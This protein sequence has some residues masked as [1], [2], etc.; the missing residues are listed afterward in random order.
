M[1]R[2]KSNR[3]WILILAIVLSVA[4]VVLVPAVGLADRGSDGVIGNNPS[5]GSGPP[6]PQGTGDPD[7]PSGSGKA[8]LQLGGGT[9]YGT[10]GSSG[11]GDAAE[12]GLAP[13]WK[14][15]IRIALGVLKTFYLRF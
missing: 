7:S 11:V 9:Y 14:L 5:D 15:R 2:F 13:A 12:S 6:D 1:R 8:N 10:I 4:G 3:W